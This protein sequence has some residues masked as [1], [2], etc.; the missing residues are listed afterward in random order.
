VEVYHRE[1]SV[2]VV[3]D[4]GHA[5]TGASSMGA[6][7]SAD[8]TA[9]ARAGSGDR[10]A[11]DMKAKPSSRLGNGN[12]TTLQDGASRRAGAADVNAGSSVGTQG[13]ATGAT[14]GASGSTS[15]S[16]NPQADTSTTTH[17]ASNNRLP[18]DRS[19]SQTGTGSTQNGGLSGP[20]STST[21]TNPG[22]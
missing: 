10:S 11:Y 2:Y 18:A 12:A 4:N 16:S 3:P 1:T 17:G 15:G 22:S 14:S 20:T 5:A 19:R 21:T 8:T 9:P 6:D 13:G 7:S